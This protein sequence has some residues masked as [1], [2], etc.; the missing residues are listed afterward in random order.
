MTARITSR[1]L[2]RRGP[3]PK[4]PPTDAAERIEALAADGFSIVGVAQHLYTSKDTLG[5]WFDEFPAL[6]ESFDRGRERERHTLHNALYRA[7]T[8][9]GNM[10]AAMFLLKA[11]HGYRE[12]DQNEQ[13]NRVS[14]NFTLP[15]AMPLAEYIDATPFNPKE[16]SNGTGKL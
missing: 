11:R 15:G 10:T 6:K 7:A 16:Q 9:Q 13:G 5:R 2:K 3:V 4:Q 8:E 12:G 1:P 14:I